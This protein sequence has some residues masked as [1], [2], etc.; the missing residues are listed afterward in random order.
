MQ[1]KRFKNFFTPSIVL[2][3]QKAKFSRILLNK[4]LTTLCRKSTQFLSGWK[5][6]RYIMFALLNRKR[7][8]ITTICHAPK[9]VKGFGKQVI[10]SS[11]IQLGEKSLEFVF[12][13]YVSSQACIYLLSICTIPRHNHKWVYFSQFSDKYF[14]LLF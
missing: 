12:N 9:S 4:K 2:W 10:C 1:K 11:I 14:F 6:A 8:S 3:A 7:H 13:S 5:T